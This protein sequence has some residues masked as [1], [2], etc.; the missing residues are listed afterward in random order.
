MLIGAGVLGLVTIVGVLGFRHI[1]ERDWLDSL[2]MVVIT[3]STVGFGEESSRPTG[4]KIWTICVIIV[5]ISAVAYIL[6]GFIQNMTEGEI[7]RALGLQR[8][9]K[10]ISRLENH[11]IVCGF[12]RMGRMVCDELAAHDQQFV[13]VE[14]D[15]ERHTEARN[16]G[17]LSCHGDATEEEI[18]EG[19]GIGKAANLVSALTSDADNVYITLTARN[20]NQSLKIIARGEF[21]S[22]RKKLMQAGA[23]RVVLPAAIGAQRIA[24][25][26]ARPF[27]AEML[28]TVI[29]DQDVGIEI[30]EFT[31]PAGSSLAGK[32][33]QQAAI[34]SHYNLL[35]IAVRSK[36]A[37]MQVNPNES[38][39]LGEG[40][41]IILLGE[42]E[43]VDRFRIENPLLGE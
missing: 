13:I 34:R 28:E 22:T 21:P 39:T 2:Y 37:K 36:E 3:L 7:Q 26:I 33:V 35:V 6:G 8:V 11:T 19:V 9:T 20:L 31:I 42:R 43:A 23:D 12:G 24:A 25:M 14:T 32:T 17:F 38:T 27:T 10:E 4:E 16:L 18:L 41:T 29:S 40:D 5:G 1:G 30:D 15:S